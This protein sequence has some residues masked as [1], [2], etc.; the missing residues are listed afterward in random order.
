[1]NCRIFFETRYEA[2][3]NDRSKNDRDA[4]PDAARDRDTTDNAEIWRRQAGEKKRPK[5]GAVPCR[6]HCFGDGIELRLQ[7]SRVGASLHTQLLCETH[8]SL[9]RNKSQFIVRLS[10]W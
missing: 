1:M 2:R 5:H 9:A 10:G 6:R 4:K 3:R 7:D 8:K